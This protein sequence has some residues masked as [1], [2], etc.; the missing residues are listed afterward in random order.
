[1]NLNKKPWIFLDL[2]CCL[3]GDDSDT[4]YCPNIEDLLPSLSK[5][6]TKKKTNNVKRRQKKQT[7]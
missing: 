2:L 1:M 3:K 6:N 5:Y 7:H 4:N